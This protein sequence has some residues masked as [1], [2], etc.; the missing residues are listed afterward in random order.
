MM[1]AVCGRFTIRS[2]LITAVSS[3]SKWKRKPE[4]SKYAWLF[5]VT[6]RAVIWQCTNDIII[7]HAARKH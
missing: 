2:K 4:I 6:N 1:N 7:R 3:V 5:D